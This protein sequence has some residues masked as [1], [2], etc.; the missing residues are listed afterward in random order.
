MGAR[1]RSRGALTGLRVM[2]AIC[3]RLHLQRQQQQNKHI[4][5]ERLHLCNLTAC[6]WSVCSGKRACTRIIGGGNGSAG[7][8][9]LVRR[10]NN[11]EP[12]DKRVMHAAS[13]KPIRYLEGGSNCKKKIIIIIIIYIYISRQ[14]R[15][16]VWW[17]YC[18]AR[19]FAAGSKET[20]GSKME[21]VLALLV[22]LWFQTWQSPQKRWEKGGR[23]RRRE[24]GGARQAQKRFLQINKDPEL[25]VLRSPRLW[26]GSSARSD[27]WGGGRADIRDRSVHHASVQKA[28]QKPKKPRVELGQPYRWKACVRSGQRDDAASSQPSRKTRARATISQRIVSAATPMT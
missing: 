18:H 27:A 4:F 6:Q 12:A 7:F 22:S 13:E 1:T 15:W 14:E 24:G 9:V 28:K 3:D 25:R 2:R 26:R 8:S 23:E 19:L 21:N 20:A 5:N 11:L 17:E 16:N 10:Q